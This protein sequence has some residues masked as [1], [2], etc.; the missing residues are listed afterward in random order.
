[1]VV[2]SL[3]DL[4]AQGGP[5]M[6]FIAGASVLAWFLALRTWWTFQDP[7]N[8]S[9]E[10]GAEDQLPGRP[11]WFGG[12]DVSYRGD[13]WSVGTDLLTSD[14]YPDRVRITPDGDVRRDPG[15]KLL[16]GLRAAFELAREVTITA[17]IDNLLDDDWYDDPTRPSGLGRG[18]YM[19]LDF[20]F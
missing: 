4:F 11:K 7:K 18:F 20:S 9:A 5:V 17:R 12:A 8:L 14:S 6:V 10:P 3:T 15:Q 16:I 13:G 2:K 19:G 1:M